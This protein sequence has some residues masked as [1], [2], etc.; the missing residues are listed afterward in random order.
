MNANETRNEMLNKVLA[1]IDKEIANCTREIEAPVL[2]RCNCIVATEDAAYQIGC[3]DNDH[4]TILIGNF[5]N[6]VWMTRR[7]AENLLYEQ[8]FQA[9]N[10]NGPL[11]FKIWGWKDFFKKR[12]EVLLEGRKSIVSAFTFAD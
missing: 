9:R 1:S 8:K 11:T 5:T 12:R 6:P 10:G 7:A 4:A 3:D 2:V